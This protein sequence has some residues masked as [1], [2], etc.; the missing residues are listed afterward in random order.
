MER[1]DGKISLLFLARI[2]YKAH[3]TAIV[4]ILPTNHLMN[5]NQTGAVPRWVESFGAE[6]LAIPGDRRVGLLEGA[7]P[8]SVLVPFSIRVHSRHSRAETLVRGEARSGYTPLQKKLNFLLA[9]F[10]ENH[11]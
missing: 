10:R 6:A 4:Q 5:A 2:A 1:G 9:F 3:S 7:L 11:L 8:G